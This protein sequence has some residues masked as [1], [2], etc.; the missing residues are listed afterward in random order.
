MS[1]YL[2]RLCRPSIPRC[3]SVIR[4]W[5]YV[6][7]VTCILCHRGVQLILDYSWARLAIL[8]AG[9]GR[10][11]CF[12][13]FCFFHSCSSFFPV[14]VFHLLYYL[15]YFFSPFLWEM[16]QNDPQ[17]FDMSL[18]PNTINCP[19]S[20]LFKRLLF[21]FFRE[22]SIMKYFLWSFSPFR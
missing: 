5:L 14:P 3:S 19:S 22:D 4:G 7:T 21:F 13:F 10:G 11:E 18:N 8:V 15:L 17:K 20:T 12:Y 9:K 6:A 1:F 2:S 16:T